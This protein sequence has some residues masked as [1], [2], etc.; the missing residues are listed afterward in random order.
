MLKYLHSMDFVADQTAGSTL[1]VRK[2]DDDYQTWSNPRMVDLGTHRPRL[3]SNGSFRRR[4]YHFRHACN[5]AL[6]I[7]AVELQLD[8]G[9]L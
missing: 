2:T 1:M 3:I 4:A 7:K 6:R 8:I 9:T 5:T